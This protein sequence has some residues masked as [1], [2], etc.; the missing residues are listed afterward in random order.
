[1]F[2]RWLFISISILLLA[3]CKP[4]VPGDVIQPDEMADILYDYHLAEAMARRIPSGEQRD[5]KQS[6]YFVD[7]LKK[8]DVTK[9]ELDS[10]LVYYYSNVDR[11]VKIY[12]QVGER[13]EEE[14]KASGADYEGVGND[15]QY[16]SASGDTT[17]IW[18]QATYAVLFADA[19]YNHLDFELKGDTATKAGDSYILNFMTDF[20]FQSGTKDAVVYV[21]ETF[22]NDSIVTFTQHIGMTGFSMVRMPGINGLK[23]KSIRGFFYLTR[24]TD[25][26]NTLKLLFINQLQLIRIRQ[27]K[28]D[29]STP[30]NGG[31]PTNQA[32]PPRAEGQSTPASPSPNETG[33]QQQLP[34]GRRGEPLHMSDVQKMK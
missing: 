25:D 9:A 10:S 22:D 4:T 12:S 15:Y 28:D 1:M 34:A 21:T 26:S 3:G 31:V 6:A 20:M 17:N 32:A 18:Q 24:G 13:I 33:P 16:A 27:P 7:V 14:G 5:F 2:G 19:P 23:M 11:L 8:H 30:Q 29:G